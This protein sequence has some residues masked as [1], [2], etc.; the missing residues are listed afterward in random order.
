MLKWFFT[1]VCAWFHSYV[2]DS[3]FFLFPDLPFSSPKVPTAASMDEGSGGQ[4]LDDDHDAGDMPLVPWDDL[5]SDDEYEADE[6]QPVDSGDHDSLEDPQSKS[7]MASA[8]QPSPAAFPVP[9]P[10]IHE[11]VPP[12][13]QTF[14][15]LLKELE[16]PAEALNPSP[17]K[18]IEA[19]DLD[20][21]A[22]IDDSPDK[23]SL[24]STSSPID[25]H[26]IKRKIRELQQNLATAKKMHMAQIFVFDDSKVLH[27]CANC[28]SLNWF[29]VP[30]QLGQIETLFILTPLNLIY[31]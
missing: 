8:S 7:P 22:V 9:E 17:S 11:E 26:E 15:D 30:T 10:C 16:S 29:P 2:W 28:F 24:G 3:C 5:G 21:C 19:D 25:G 4:P 27:M 31:S 14:D 12:D 1:V 6:S 23:C 18:G 20:K 13:S